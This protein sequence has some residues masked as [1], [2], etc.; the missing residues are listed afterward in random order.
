MYRI[1][2]VETLVRVLSAI[3]GFTEDDIWD[4]QGIYHKE[5]GIS[6]EEMLQIPIDQVMRRMKVVS[7]RKQKEQRD[8][9]RQSSQQQ[10]RRQSARH[11]SMMYRRTR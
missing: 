1:P 4:I 7:E 9:E 8:L 5:Y 3:E 2:V 10:G 6:R 11:P